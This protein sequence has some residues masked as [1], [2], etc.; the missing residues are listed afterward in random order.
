MVVDVAPVLPQLGELP[1]TVLTLPLQVL[2]DAALLPVGGFLHVP[3]EQSLLK[4]LLPTHVTPEETPEIPGHRR[5]W[6]W[7]LLS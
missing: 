7:K 5:H 1:S 6:P 2:L 4:E 3:P